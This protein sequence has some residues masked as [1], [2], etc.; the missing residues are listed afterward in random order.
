MRP[1]CHVLLVIQEHQ[2]R[3]AHIEHRQAF[4]HGISYPA[5]LLV[6]AVLGFEGT[7]IGL[8]QAAKVEAG[9][10][11]ALFNQNARPFVFP[12]NPHGL[13]PA[14]RSFH[15]HHAFCLAVADAHRSGVRR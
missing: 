6:A 3:E 10:P 1:M 7:R 2:R 11:A 15:G 9:A 14:Q 8:A 5:A 4:L 13:G 12:L